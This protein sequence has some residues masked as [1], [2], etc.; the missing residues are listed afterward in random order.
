MSILYNRIAGQNLD[1]VAALSDG[2]FAVAMTLLVLDLKV[3]PLGDKSANNL[4]LWNALLSNFVSHLLPWIMS[5]ITLGIFWVGQQ[6]QLNKCV[7]ADR[8]LSW[9]HLFFLLCVSLMPFSTALLATYM[10]LTLALWIYWFNI[11][12]LGVALLISWRYAR[13]AGL[14]KPDFPE[15][16][17]TAVERRILIAQGL[18]A[19]GAALSLV[20]A[21]T[22][23]SIVAII[24]VQLNFVFAPRIPW[25]S[26][27]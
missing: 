9:I 11:L 27:I 4:D 24:L 15:E 2:I 10:H 19:G 7:R 1:R 20:F 8:N 26:R 22:M 18:Y 23:V 14:L 5:F 16:L 6:T 13:R 12:V 21:D 25:L 17:T 3:P